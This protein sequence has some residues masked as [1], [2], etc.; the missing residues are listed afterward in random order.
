M[1]TPYRRLSDAG[2]WQRCPAAPRWFWGADDNPRSFT[3]SHHQLHGSEGSDARPRGS[4]L[5]FTGR[6]TS[7][8]RSPCGS[9]SGPDTPFLLPPG[10]EFYDYGGPQEHIARSL[11]STRV[12]LWYRGPPVIQPERWRLLSLR[13][14]LAMAVETYEGAERGKNQLPSL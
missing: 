8:A 3:A 1:T 6:E 14:V 7:H 11:V 9:P 4:R 2:I 10:F 5:I 13:T 12:L